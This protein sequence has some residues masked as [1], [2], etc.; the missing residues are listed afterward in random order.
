MIDNLRQQSATNQVVKR[1][2]KKGDVVNLDFDGKKDG[3]PVEGA[4]GKKRDLVIGE[5][6]FLADFEK[7]L[8]GLKKG[9]TKKFSVTFPKDYPEI[10]LQNQKVDFSAKVNQV[11]EAIPA[12]LD[13]DF[14]EKFG[15]KD[16]VDLKAAIKAQL[17]TEKT[18][19]A[20][21]EHELAVVDEIVAK[22]Y[23]ER[24]SEFARAA[25]AQNEAR[26]AAEFDGSRNGFGKIFTDAQSNC[27]A[28]RCRTGTGSYPKA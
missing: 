4:S 27:R 1:S 16:E 15:L 6:V 2:S 13:K 20:Q 11:S 19:Q 21:L 7:N 14:F 9:E 17:T 3:Q 24:T 8:I 18:D 26:H 28:I 12:K 5:G 23:P 25:I 10:T 22:K